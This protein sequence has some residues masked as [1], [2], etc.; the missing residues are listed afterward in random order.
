MI[1]LIK[2]VSNLDDFNYIKELKDVYINWD[3]DLEKYS[4]I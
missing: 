4:L 2:W 1:V 3:L